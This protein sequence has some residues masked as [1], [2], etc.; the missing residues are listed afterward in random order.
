MNMCVCVCVCVCVCLF[1][2]VGDRVREGE[3]FG[4]ICEFECKTFKSECVHFEN[5]RTHSPIHF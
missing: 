2:Y 3:L 1:K 4:A 5:I